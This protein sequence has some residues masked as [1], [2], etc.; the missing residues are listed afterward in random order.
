[1]KSTNKDTKNSW[2]KYGTFKQR[3]DSSVNNGRIFVDSVS[4]DSVRLQLPD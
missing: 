3:L 1:M 4:D 2:K